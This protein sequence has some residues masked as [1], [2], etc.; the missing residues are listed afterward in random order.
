VILVTFVQLH[1]FASPF[2]VRDRGFYRD[3]S[4]FDGIF[5]SYAWFAGLETITDGGCEP[6]GHGSDRPTGPLSDSTGRVVEPAAGRARHSVR[7]AADWRIP[8]DHDGALIL[9][10]AV[11]A[12]S[13]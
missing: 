2:Q 3:G 8:I 13:L 7:A 1:S 5:G 6:H 10:S 4:C 12:T 11:G 9:P